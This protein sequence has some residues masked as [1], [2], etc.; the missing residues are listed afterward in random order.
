M[1]K[2]VRDSF[3]LP[4]NLADSDRADE[5]PDRPPVKKY[6]GISQVQVGSLIT[7]RS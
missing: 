5:P 6:A 2:A 3:S 1:Y 7:G 4:N